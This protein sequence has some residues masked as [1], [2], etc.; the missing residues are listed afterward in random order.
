MKGPLR[1]S[2]QMTFGDIEGCTGSE[3]SPSGTTPSDSPDSTPTVRCGPLAAR[4]NLSHRQAKE[5]GLTTSGTYGPLSSGSSAS[6]DLSCALVN[7]LLPLT[8]SLG[9]T[10]FVLTWKALATPSGRWLP[11]LRASAR[12]TPDTESTGSQSE[13]SP[14]TARP[15]AQARDGES[16]GQAKRAHQEGTSNNLNDFAL[17]TEQLKT[18]WPSPTATLSDK[19]VRS[20][21]GAQREAARNHGPDLG[22]VAALTTWATPRTSDTNGAGEHGE[23]GADLRTMAQM[24]LA[25]PAVGPDSCSR[26]SGMLNGDS[27]PLACSVLPVLPLSPRVTAAARDWKDSEGMSTEGPNGRVRLDQLPR[28]A[29]LTDSG[30]TPTGSPAPTA[31]KGQ[32]NPALSRWLM[33]LPVSWD[34]CALRVVPT[35]R[36]RNVSSTPRSS[37]KAKRGR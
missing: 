23:G 12:R 3:A 4:V 6:A 36:T 15:T 7:R 14:A 2:R 13:E 25:E 8:A 21:E 10:L 35:V 30:Q 37:K 34:L 22:S 11:L 33:G 16:G 26:G 28:Q 27:A 29:Q 1:I 5:R 9:S 31:S 24:T 20:L 18:G 32:L 19:G 17:L